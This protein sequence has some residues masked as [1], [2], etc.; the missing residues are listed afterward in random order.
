[1]FISN[2][3]VFL[4]S[5]VPQKE[6]LDKLMQKRFCMLKMA[7]W[8]ADDNSFQVN[9][10]D[11]VEGLTEIAIKDIIRPPMKEN[12]NDVYIGYKL[13]D[14]YLH[15]IIRSHQDLTDD[16]CRVCTFYFL[17]A[18]S[19]LFGYQELFYHIR[20]H[21]FISYN[22]PSFSCIW[23][24]KIYFLIY[25]AWYILL[26]DH[27]HIC[28]FFFTCVCLIGSPDESGL[29][30]LRNDNARRYV[31]MVPQFPK[32]NVSV[33]FPNVSLGAVDLLEKTLV[34]DPNKHITVDEALCHPYLAPFMIPMRSLFA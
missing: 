5:T 25:D 27:R 32:Q 28:I 29:G 24:A 9:H 4:S 6:I 18:L 8:Y 11:F 21:F 13:M 3:L 34:F 15:Q 17:F 22:F 14:T 19:R 31:R 12:F 26:C 10:F 30:F 1:M 33:R 7:V 16:H 20:K 23:L 2:S